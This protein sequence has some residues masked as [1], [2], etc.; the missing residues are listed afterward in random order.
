MNI[1]GLISAVLGIAGVSV[2]AI[3]LW[4]AAS[5]TEP[6][7]VEFQRQ[8]S[9]SI[10][11][12]VWG[13]GLQVRDY[14]SDLGFEWFRVTAAGEAVRV[15][16]SMQDWLTTRFDQQGVPRVGGRAAERPAIE[17]NAAQTMNDLLMQD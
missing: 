12:R 5:G 17:G 3:A 9:G 1:N 4:P 11:A 15:E 13:P 14:T 8:P 10:T 16:E 7:R 2:I 6:V